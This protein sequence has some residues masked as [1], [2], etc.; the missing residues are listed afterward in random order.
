MNRQIHPKYRSGFFSI[1]DPES[2]SSS[3]KAPDPGSA[4]QDQAVKKC[5]T[6]WIIT[7]VYSILYNSNIIISFISKSTRYGKRLK[8]IQEYCHHKRSGNEGGWPN[9][10]AYVP[11]YLRAALAKEYSIISAGFMGWKGGGGGAGGARMQ[12][13]D[14]ISGP[15]FVC[16]KE[17]TQCGNQPALGSIGR[18]LKM[19]LQKQA[20]N[21]KI[22]MRCPS[23]HTRINQSHHQCCGSGFIESRSGSS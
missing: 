2:G 14:L 19:Q 13:P 12:I 9:C 5:A 7:Y 22:F 18:I 16:G 4:T 20:L 17:K 21:F 11:L 6:L 15:E 10:H 23:V 3:Q 8:V 1:P